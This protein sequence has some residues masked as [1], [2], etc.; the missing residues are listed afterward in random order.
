MLD[1]KLLRKDL[2]LVKQRMQVRAGSID[3]DSFVELDAAR[4]DKQVVVE[5]LQAERNKSAKMV[6]MAKAK[7]EDVTAILA[8]INDV[9]DQMKS[10]EAEL[11]AIQAQLDDFLLRLPNIPDADVPEGQDESAN[12]LV[13]EVGDKPEFEFKPLDHVDVGEGL[14]MLDLAAAAKLSG[15]RFCVLKGDLVRLQRALGQYMLDMHVLE[16]GYVE[17][18]VPLLVQADCLQGTG[19]F[20]KF[21]EDV[22]TV[23]GDKDLS[24]IPTAE[25]ALT[26]L[27]REEIIDL[28]RLPLKMVAQTPCFRSEAGSYGRDTR[29]LIR[30]HQFEKVEMVQVVHPTRSEDVLEEMLAHAEKVLQGLGLA[31]RVVCLCGGDLGFSARKTYDLE[32]WMPSQNTYREISSISNCGDFQ[33]RRMQARFAASGEKP[34]LVH[35]LN[36]SGVAVGR[37]L[38][39]VLE[40]YQQAD[41]RVKVPDVLKPYLAGLDYLG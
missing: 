39:A 9:G 34:V 27:V 1:N 22:F 24:L 14:G 5:S 30:Q 36:G 12:K 29:G 4:R 33:A 41:G 35:T 3:W 32:V 38:I 16:H 6:G 23:Q 37:A 11:Q 26:N 7:G 15:S 2:E 21:A 31:Y 28:E 17:H 8:Q 18:Y 25:V 13:R 10:A 19:Q 40:N 20:P